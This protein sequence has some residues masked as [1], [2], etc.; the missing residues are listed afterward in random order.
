M[1]EEKLNPKIYI[2]QLEDN[3][4]KLKDIILQKA[5]KKANLIYQNKPISNNE[6]PYNIYDSYSKIENSFQ[7]RSIRI[8]RLLF[9]I[10]KILFF[11]SLLIIPIFLIFLYFYQFEILLFLI[12][13]NVDTLLV[14]NLI[15]IMNES[16]QFIRDI[17][18]KIFNLVNSIDFFN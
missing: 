17:Y 1:L 3:L 7:N 18:N 16:I 9:K 15:D 2:K 14:S 4:I 13:N 12:R 10:I 5:S 11:T 6:N 8:I